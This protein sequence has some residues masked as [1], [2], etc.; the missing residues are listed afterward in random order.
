MNIDTNYIKNIRVA[1][2]KAGYDVICKRLLLEK[3][4]LS[5]ERGRFGYRFIKTVECT[6]V[7]GNRF[8]G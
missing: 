3:V 4:I 8:T 2:E 7:H 6:S 1:D 5:W